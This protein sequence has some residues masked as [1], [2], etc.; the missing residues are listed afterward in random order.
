MNPCIHQICI[1]E[2]AWV[3]IISLLDR[4]SNIAQQRVKYWI[5]DQILL[6]TRPIWTYQRGAFYLALNPHDSL[7]LAPAYWQFRTLCIWSPTKRFELGQN[8]RFLTCIVHLSTHMQSI[9]TKI[10]TSQSCLAWKMGKVLN[11]CQTVLCKG[12]KCYPEFEVFD[13][14]YHLSCSAECWQ[15]PFCL[16][17]WPIFL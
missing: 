13:T 6:K 14:F 9:I 15:S 8:H 11:T 3:C 12:V 1:C 16:L 7:H 5:G 4:E 10:W 17:K 2:W